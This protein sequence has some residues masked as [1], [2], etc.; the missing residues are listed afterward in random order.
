MAYIR[1]P[2][3]VP[4]AELSGLGGLISG[5]QDAFG[6]TAAKELADNTFTGD[7]NSLP[8]C[9]NASTAVGTWCRNYIGGSPVKKVTA[10]V[11][12]APVAAP[13]PAAGPSTSDI[14]GGLFKSLTGAIGTS[15]MTPAA[16]AAAIPVQQAGMSTGTKVAIAGG[17]VALLAVILATR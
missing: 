15:T 12:P 1:R 9:M 6:I 11:A 8:L 5:L 17:A 4:R 16:Q 3:R 2:S 7:V 10:T 13:K 14:L